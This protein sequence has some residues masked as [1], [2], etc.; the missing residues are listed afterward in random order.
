MRACECMCLANQHIVRER[1]HTH[2]CIDRFL[3][4]SVYWR[5]GGAP[6]EWGVESEIPCALLLLYGTC[7][8]AVC[9]PALSTTVKEEE[10]HHLKN[11]VENRAKSRCDRMESRLPETYVFHKGLE[12]RD[13]KQHDVDQDDAKVQKVHIRAR[14]SAGLR[15]C[16]DHEHETIWRCVCRARICT[17]CDFVV[18]AS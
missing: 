6:R 12:N 17:H 10:G 5:E 15:R 16:L 2:M 18:I 4:Y 14:C 3:H 8:L 7:C 1:A 11:N 13:G 9:P